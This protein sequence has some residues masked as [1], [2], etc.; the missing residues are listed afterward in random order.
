[1]KNELPAFDTFDESIQYYGKNIQNCS[2]R[3]DFCLIRWRFSNLVAYMAFKG[4]FFR[5]QRSLAV[6][7]VSYIF[8]YLKRVINVSKLFSKFYEKN[9]NMSLQLINLNYFQIL[10]LSISKML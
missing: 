1:M 8:K 6:I 7:N 9:V 10:I 4:L 5:T 2:T 3:S